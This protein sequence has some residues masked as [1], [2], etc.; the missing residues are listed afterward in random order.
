MDEGG[1]WDGD[2]KLQCLG[3][4]KQQGTARLILPKMP[5]KIHL[6][7]CQGKKDCINNLIQACNRIIF[8]VNLFILIQ[9][10]SFNPTIYLV[11][12]IPYVIWTRSQFKNSEDSYPR[13]NSSVSYC[14]QIPW[15]GISLS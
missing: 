14:T 8:Y 13:I 6:T 5:T 2:A 3:K 7:K 11:H 4:F 15:M 12:H 10:Y 1:E 9:L